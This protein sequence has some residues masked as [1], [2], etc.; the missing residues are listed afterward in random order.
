MTTIPLSCGDHTFR[1]LSLEQAA[2][3]I[4]MLDL[5]GMDVA[6]SGGG[7]AHVRP[8]DV[9]TDVAGWAMT[10]RRCLSAAGLRPADVF[11]IPWTDF[12]TLAPNSPDPDVR[13]ESRALFG[14]MA[15]FAARIGAPGITTLPGLH[16][17]DESHRDSLHRAAEEL[18]WRAQRAA[19]VELRF[20]IEAHVGSVC[21]TP[22]AA[23]DLLALAS[24]VEL[25]LD[26]SHFVAQGVEP[27]RVHRLLGHAR[28]V[29]VRGTR[30]DRL[31]CG[32]QHS[33]VDYGD[34]ARRLCAGGYE[35][36]IAI[37]YLWADWQH[38]NECDTVSETIVLRDLLRA[39][40][41]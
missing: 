9:R 1:L 18:T 40:M 23:L 36:S 25:T 24:G 41:G 33:T 31:Q 26:Y 13:A 37:E 4:A 11:L 21:A 19:A 3:L 20:S 39:Q 32:L 38:M 16:W 27:E 30:P 5:Q 17:P 14:E 2:R 15:D 35:G 29:H 6:A 28:H 12:E 10:V 34:V 8:E 22:E 7:D